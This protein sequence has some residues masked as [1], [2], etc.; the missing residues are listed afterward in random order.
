M[1]VKNKQQVLESLEECINHLNKRTGNK[2]KKKEEK[3]KI[4]PTLQKAS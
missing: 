3:K 1:K 4:K 2:A